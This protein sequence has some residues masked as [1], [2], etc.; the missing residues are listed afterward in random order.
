MTKPV[1]T[2]SACLIVRDEEAFLEGC[3][4]SLRDSVDEIVI[5]DT[6]STDRT[7]E[8]ARDF[9][10][11]VVEVPWENDFSTARNAVIRCAAS[12]W[13]LSIDADERLSGFDRNHVEQFAGDTSIL[14]ARSLL[15]PQT[16]W[17][18]MHVMRLFRNDP[19]TRFTNI[20]HETVQPSITGSGGG[21][22]EMPFI[23]EHLGYDGDM[24][25][26]HARALPLLQRQLAITPD[27]VYHLHHLGIVH[28]AMDNIRDAVGAWT[29]GME[30]VM[31]KRFV[32]ALD[33]CPFTDL[34]QLY[35][36]QDMP[37]R[38]LLDTAL[39]LFP[40]HP[41]L[42]WL[43]SQTLFRERKFREAIEHLESLVEI[44]ERASYDRDMSYHESMFTEFAFDLLGLCYLNLR[45]FDTGARWFGKAYQCN[46]DNQTYRMKQKMAMA[47]KT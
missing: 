30:A 10:A 22:A 24:R 40:N 23:I 15:L 19:R 38:E 21:A 4:A 46:P 18:P 7:I 2:I 26:K 16:G 29:R 11:R 6:G 44:G 32:S 27:S 43:N 17:T 25:L 35:Q 42:V 31:K 12:A 28:Q 41:D 33:A 20:I 14:A 3:L 39:G 37:V 13:I 1:P 47:Q 36:D 8:I 5:G 9:G 45:Q 34:I